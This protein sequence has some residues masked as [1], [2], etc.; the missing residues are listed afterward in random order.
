MA[1]RVASGLHRYLN[2]HVTSNN[3]VK[4][5]YLILGVETGNYE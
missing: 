3:D 2:M 1:A 4:R 5:F